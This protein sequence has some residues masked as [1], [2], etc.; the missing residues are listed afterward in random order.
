MILRH[1]NEPTT[2]VISAIVM[3]M[4]LMFH[5]MFQTYVASRFGD[6]SPRFA[7]FNN[8]DPQHHLEPFGVI[9][10][11]ILGFGWPKPIP[12]NSRNY[13]RKQEAWVWYAGPLA[14]LIVAFVS[15]LVAVVFAV[16]GSVELFRAF[17]VAGSFA[18]LHAVIN[19]F[20]VYPLDG[21]KA[22]LV[23]GNRQVRQLVQQVAQFG[24]LGFVVIF[25]VL[26]M[27]SI[28]GAM[29]SFFFRLI[30]GIIGLI[31]GL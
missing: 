9:L 19:L 8:F 13:R 15:I 7:G 31:P 20:P 11:F 18:I 23:W 10:L 3:I 24:I 28:L 17:S 27:T 4:A 25:L 14:Y 5:N 12:A 16:A 22:A 1:F 2:L 6:H 26:S 29:T 21:A 30:L